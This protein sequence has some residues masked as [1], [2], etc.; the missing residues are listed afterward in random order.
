M[1]QTQSRFEQFTSLLVQSISPASLVAFRIGFGLVLA[2]HALW[3]LAPNPEGTRLSREYDAV[4]T[5]FTYPGFS[6]VQP[7]SSPYLAL[8]FGLVA[9]AGLLVAVGFCYRLA[10]VCLFLAYTYTFLLDVAYYNNHYYLMSLIAL[11]LIAMPAQTSFSV[12][13]WLRSRRLASPG[14]RRGSFTGDAA[15]SIPF[16]PVFLLRAQLFIVYFFGGLAKFNTDWL[17]G[18]PLLAPGIKL[19]EFLSHTAGLP[20]WVTVQQLCL[21]LAWTGLVF[22]LS[23]GFLL[24][25]RRTR[26]LGL[27]LTLIFHFTNHNLFDIGVFPAMATVSTLIFLEPDWPLRIWNWIRTPR[28]FSPDWNWFVGG[29]L[30][31]PLVGAALGWKIRPSGAVRSACDVSRPH[32]MAVGV[33]TWIVVQAIVPLRH[34][35]IPGDAN[36]TDEGHYFAWRMMLRYKSAQ[37]LDFELEDPSLASDSRNGKPH[38]DW[39]QWPV[40]VP[41]AMFLEVDAQQVNWS[42]LPEILVIYEELTG[43]RIFYNPSAASAPRDHSLAACQQRVSQIWQAHY[44]RVPEVLACLGPDEA[45]RQLR[46]EIARSEPITSDSRLTKADRVAQISLALDYAEELLAQP[47]SLDAIAGDKLGNYLES[48]LAGTQGEFVGRFLAQVGPFGLDGLK[49]NPSLYVI[50]DPQMT[51]ANGW[52]DLRTWYRTE[53]FPVYVDTSRLRVAGWK[54]LPQVVMFFRDGKPRPFWN[55]YRDLL[56]KQIEQLGITPSLLHQYAGHVAHQWERLTNRPAVVHV[57]APVTLNYRPYQVLVDPRVD[58]ATVPYRCLEHNPWISML[59]GEVPRDM[60]PTRD[61]FPKGAEDAKAA[62]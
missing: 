29:A 3:V 37:N 58:L 8:V 53:N 35:A 42:R 51:M 56:P 26:L 27:L 17:T 9:V 6:W 44:H 13:A 61:M 10:A 24:T 21:F 45:L 22:D 41:Q 14:V 7:L 54:R 12:D 49:Q 33:L 18:V 36:W 1:A 57:T 52:R 20:S 4:A 62:K 59:Q 5:H 43:G 16:W 40:D 38:V 30:A 47:G 55:H 11:L 25:F 2:Y 31:I 60:F 48:L 23:I 32:W 34:L 28:F 19:H 50:R 15:T 39:S 46:Q